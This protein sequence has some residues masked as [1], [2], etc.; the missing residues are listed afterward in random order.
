[1]ILVKSITNSCALPTLQDTASI[2]E[3]NPSY[4]KLGTK[5]TRSSVAQLTACKYSPILDT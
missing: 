5:N 3:Q 4:C 1:M 2:T